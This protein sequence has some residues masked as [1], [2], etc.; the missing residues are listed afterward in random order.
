[1]TLFRR[2]IVKDSVLGRMGMRGRAPRG[3]GGKGGAEGAL[4]AHAP[5]LRRHGRARHLTRLCA[6]PARPIGERLS[7]SMRVFR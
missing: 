2:G 5:E 6:P 7:A 1:V 3:W 4:P